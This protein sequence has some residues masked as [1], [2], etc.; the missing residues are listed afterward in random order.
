MIHTSKNWLKITAMSAVLLVS[1]SIF[2]FQYSF[3][4][5]DFSSAD[6]RNDSYHELGFQNSVGGKSTFSVSSEHICMISV[7]SMVYCQ[8]SNLYGQLGSQF[9]TGLSVLDVSDFG[10]P[11]ELST[12]SK[13]SCL[14]TDRSLVVCWGA[15]G[16]NKNA[17]SI[18]ESDISRIPKIVDLKDPI[19]SISSGDEHACAISYSGQVH[20][21][22][23]IGSGSSPISTFEVSITGNIRAIDISSGGGVICLIGPS[24][25]LFCTYPN[26][27][28]PTDYHVVAEKTSLRV[29]SSVIANSHDICF[30]NFQSKLICY[31]LEKIFTNEQEDQLIISNTY[32]EVRVYSL[33]SDYLCMVKISN[34]MF[35][36]ENDGKSHLVESSVLPAISVGAEKFCFVSSAS[37]EFSCR[38]GIFDTNEYPINREIMLL[39]IDLDGDG[40]DNHFDQYMYDYDFSRN[41]GMGF[42]GNFD[43][44]PASP[45]NYV[46]TYR[47]EES[48]PCPPGEYQNESAQ[49]QCKTSDPGFY[50]DSEGSPNQTPC[51]PGTFSEESGATSLDVCVAVSPGE[52]SPGGAQSGI[53]CPPGTYQPDPGQESCIDSD[54]GHYSEGS[55]SVQQEE[56]LP[57]TYQP[58]SSR[59]SCL[60]AEKGNYVGTYRAEESHPCP[61]GEYQ[62]ESAQSQCKTSDPGFYVDS[63]G[64]P[65]QTPCPPGTFSEESGATSLDVC[66]AVSPGEYSP[67]GAQSGIPCP[68]GTYQPDPGQESCIDSDPGHYSEGSGSVQQEECLPGTYMPEFGAEMCSRAASGH[69]VAVSAST[70]QSECEP[71]TFQP[72]YESISCIPA[73]PGFF[74]KEYAQKSMNFCQPGSFQ[75]SYG[76]TSCIIAPKNSFSFSMGNTMAT[77]CGKGGITMENN[78]SSPMD[79]IFDS[80]GDSIIDEKDSWPHSQGAEY[81]VSWVL[82]SILSTISAFSLIALFN[83]RWEIV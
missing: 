53:P 62:N 19:A 20:C 12:G 42:F 83:K 2:S 41:C 79:C 61:P 4:N 38:E 22:D 51:P 82:L 80:D 66:V 81:P 43:C 50:V 46:G 1:G 44:T 8:G 70:Y 64:S 54:P 15:M 49:S 48:H 76:S 72:K 16:G 31:P 26:E 25:D 40:A 69:F 24:E 59:D 29:F 39:T 34:E 63:E 47:A 68:P 71:G 74:V 9:T 32:S 18:F 57:G 52:Y 55:G 78:T 35:C 33:G 17:T 58:E 37:F 77:P 73:T 30:F 5:S 3:A 67:G 60:E 28:L 65:N 11:T 10:S 45:G 27:R 6:N 13:H 7:D 56:C 21:W 36:E 23:Y 14:L 75:P